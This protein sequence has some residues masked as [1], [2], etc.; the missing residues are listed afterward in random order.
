M[1]FR[2]YVAFNSCVMCV[3]SPAALFREHLRLRERESSTYRANGAPLSNRY[4]PHIL[5]VAAFV[6]VLALAV[7]PS[8]TSAQD[9]IP[10]PTGELT[11]DPE[12]IRVGET[13][14]VSVSN[15][16][17]PD[18]RVRI[19]F[20]DHFVS[21][22]GACD[23]A[24]ATSTAPAAT[25][26]A[27]STAPISI[28]L[29]ACASGNAHVRLVA[30]DTEVVMA[31]KDM[32]IAEEDAE[33]GCVIDGLPCICHD[34][35]DL[36]PPTAT[37]TPTNTPTPTPTNT[38]TPTP[39][40][41]P[42]P[43]PTSTGTPTPTPTDTPTPTYT[44]TPTR[45]PRSGDPR[46]PRFPALSAP[47]HT[48]SPDAMVVTVRYIL[49]SQPGS[50][51]YNLAL[52]SSATGKF[53]DTVLYRHADV[54][55][56]DG[57][58]RFTQLVLD[59]SSWY[60]LGLL[61]CRNTRLRNCGT[62]ALGSIWQPPAPPDTATAPGR[63]SPPT[64]TS[65]N[66]RL[67]VAWAA[68][69][70]GGSAITGYRVQHRLTTE[71]W[72]GD[73]ASVAADTTKTEVTGLTNDV[74]YDVRVRAC[75]IEGC[76]VWST[77]SRGTPRAANHPPVIDSGPPSVSY[78]EN[79]TS[80]V[81]TYTASDQDGDP[82]SW[83]LPNTTHAVDRSDFTVTSGGVL[84]F[85]SSPDYESPHDS[86]GDNEYRVTVRASDGAGAVDRNVTVTVTNLDEKGSVRLS[87]VSPR[88]NSVVSATLSDPDGGVS[89][90]VWQWQRSSDGVAWERISGAPTGGSYTPSNTDVGQ[91]LRVSVTYAD[92]HGT[93]KSAVS[94]R[95]NVVARPY[96]PPQPPARVEGLMGSPGSNRGEIILDWQPAARADS[97]EVQ[98]RRRRFPLLPTYHWVTI[99]TS[100]TTGAVVEGL[101]GGETYRHRVRGVSSSGVA[102]P[103]SK[104]VDTTLTLPARVV[105][106]TGTPGPAHGAITLAWDPTDGATGYEVQQ[107]K[108]RPF[109]LPDEWIELS[110][111]D[112]KIDVASTTA[113]VRKLDP[114]ETYEHRVRGANV[115]GEGEW[116]D[117]VRTTPHDERPD[118]P[119]GLVWGTIR[120]GRGVFL[121]WNVVTDAGEYDVE[122]SFGGRTATTTVSATSVEFIGL[123][124]EARYSFRV[125]AWKP[126][127]S[128][129]LHSEW[130][131]TVSTEAPTPANL[132]HQEDHTVAYQ[133]GTITSAP[134][135][136]AGVQDPAMVISDAIE[137][138]AKAWTDEAM[139]I[140]GK[141]L[142]ICKEDEDDCGGNHDGGIVTVKTVAGTST[143]VGL[144]D[145]DH[146]HDC[147][148]S[149]GCVK[150][151]STFDSAGPGR[152]LGHMS[153]II[154]EPAWECREADFSGDCVDQVRTYW[155]DV[156]DD[157]MGEVKDSRTGTTLGVKYYIPPLMIHE[158]GHTLGLP[159]FGNVPTLS[160]WPAVM[161]DLH[162]NQMITGED[163]AQLRAIYALHDSSDH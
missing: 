118:T 134:G 147:G 109:L 95:T 113:E 57:S 93:G 102:G 13:T 138:A 36:C 149:V 8:G 70:N 59:R 148:G 116:S 74:A 92:T 46:P 2:P 161:D 56:G 127:G 144:P 85:N 143:A 132:G 94:D 75:N 111:D 61:A 18:Q 129:R 123:T 19:E 142:N 33:Q 21:E 160:N 110:G 98:Q 23:T 119:Q 66:E 78:P 41:T 96:R 53:N 157:H 65:G 71:S 133:Q 86:N 137:P 50:F 112:I 34:Y 84:S 3:D 29:A 64:I 7:L 31:E 1:G 82:V 146:D 48:V 77:S 10:I 97:Y 47:T 5:L 83:S 6:A 99:V 9:F 114:D 124:P 159:D 125:R 163:V 11:V 131:D 162:A 108:P 104:H 154:E 4:I 120:G 67:S 26:T 25:T 38:P 55:G 140:A 79:G 30:S 24:T 49:P 101:T 68:P 139:A 100:T 27:S 115:H 130:S 87:S 73:G 121:R 89:S 126:H 54:T 60:Q 105:G 88:V 22:G 150:F 76:G 158:F 136:P 15:V 52:Y 32:V 20:S 145:T 155:T 62:P 16:V 72:S 156:L 39:T 152:H 107:K 90:P 35:P 81:S 80:S 45:T 128:S 122:S 44:P 135:R 151:D 43:T 91:R 12:F 63:V 69:P 51:R 153:L 58:H 14:V 117:P 37:P 103:W 28:T 17:P 40:Y 106:L 42:T 141:N